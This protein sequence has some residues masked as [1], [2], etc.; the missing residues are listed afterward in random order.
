MSTTIATAALPIATGTWVVDKTHSTVEFAV[1]HMGISKVRGTFSAFDAELAVGDSLEQTRL[2]A[3]VGLSSI[4]TK[5]SMRDGHLR[6]TDFFHVEKHP[7]MSFASRQIVAGTDGRLTV[8]GDLTLNGVTRT[9]RFD[10]EFLG[11]AIFPM[12]GSSHAGFEATGTLSRKEYGIDFNVPLAAGG[13]VISDTIE[14]RLDI[15][16]MPAAEAPAY[17]QKFMPTA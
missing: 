17:H 8:I 9:Q 2:S 14:I 16:L 13:V 3:T 1:R 5:N 4:D 6:T 15:Q 12:D 11:T 7:S 10:V